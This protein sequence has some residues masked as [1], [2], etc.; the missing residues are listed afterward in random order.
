MLVSIYQNVYD[1]TSQV[2]VNVE[3]VLSSIKKGQYKN[4]IHRLR[5]SDDVSLKQR[6]KTNLT[7][8]C[9][10]GKFNKREDKEITEHSGLVILDFDHVSNLQEFKDKI[11]KDIFTYSA[12]ISP[13]GDGLKVLFKIPKEIDNHESYYLGIVKYCKSCGYHELDTTSKNISRVCFVSYDPEIYINKNC[14]T[15]TTKGELLVTTTKVQIGEAQATEYDK[16][17]ICAEIIRNSTDGNKHHNL[18]KASRLA[19]GYIAG[20]YVE[21][22]EAVRVLE[23]EINRKNPTNFKLACKTIQDG[24]VYGKQSPIEKKDYK[25]AYETIIKENIIIKDEPAKDVILCQDVKDKILYSYEHGTSLGETTYLRSL[26]NAYRMKRGEVTLVHGIPNFGKSSFLYQLALIKSVKDGYKW[27]VFSPENMPVEEFYKDLIHAYIGKSTEPYHSN[28][29]SSAELREGIDFIN[30]HFFLIYPKDDTP[31]PE[32]MN[33]RFAELVIKHNISGCIT[34][35]Y[36]QLDTDIMK[37]GGR[38][39]QYLSWYLTQAKRFAVEQ[40][41][42]YFI[43]AHPKS[44]IRVVDGNYEIP[45]AYSLSGG[46]MWNNKCDNIIAVHRPNFLLDKDD[47][48]VMVVSQKIKKQKICG[49]PQAIK[50]T[51]N[52]D[53]GRYYIDDYTPLRN[54]ENPYTDKEFAEMLIPDINKEIESEK[55]IIKIDTNFKTIKSFYEVEND[56][57]DI[58]NLPQS[59]IKDIPF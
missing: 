12:F 47:K 45:N 54:F 10:S 11:C 7:S 1:K 32:Y 42:F 41:L 8:V 31:T 20:G 16:L 39:D 53:T 37:K 36:N 24:I 9:F 4:D 19:G 17:N 13:S 28:K 44:G 2:Y 26:D 50:L 23:L 35:P 30:E 57:D 49:I 27:G 29:M 14:D 6:I 59:K 51:Y 25:K 33:N 18:I 22:H 5:Q 46:A 52:R 55:S 3:R 40:N 21:E 56:E 34:D 48:T 15:F 38:E 43:I 58:W